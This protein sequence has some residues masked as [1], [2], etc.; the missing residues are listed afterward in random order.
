VA[1]A[2]LK[3][4]GDWHTGTLHLTAYHLIFRSNSG[5]EL[6]VG[7]PLM[8]AVELVKPQPVRSR[9]SRRSGAA[10][11]AAGIGRGS[12]SPSATPATPDDDDASSVYSSS[13]DGASDSSVTT[14]TAATTNSAAT[15]PGDHGVRNTT[16][17]INI[18]CH[19]FLM[20]SLVCPTVA[21]TCD[22]FLT[23]QN[24]ICV[25]SVERLYAFHYRP[26]ELATG[27]A[28]NGWDIYDPEKEFRRMG[29]GSAAGNDLGANWRFTDL[30]CNYQLSPTYPRIL[31]VPARITDTTLA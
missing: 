13:H 8:Y 3:K 1:N 23:I 19:D 12:G 2:R 29:V 21:E 22:V 18:Q 30:N 6:W 10:I 24:L 17:V 16:G 31:V 14:T 26:L 4:R 15:I 27:A 7:Y 28:S 5:E 20:I 9:K 25:D 11:A